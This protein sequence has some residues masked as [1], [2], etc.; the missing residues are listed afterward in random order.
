MQFARFR[1]NVARQDVVQHDV[2]NEIR[3]VKLFIVILFDVLQ[4]HRDQ[5][6]ITA[7]QIIGALY[8]YGVVV[9]LI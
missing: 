6:R 7:C 9:A 2:F 3:F 1:V 8:K 5:R 4:R